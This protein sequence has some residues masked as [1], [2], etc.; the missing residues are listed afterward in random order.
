M[1]AQMRRNA[2]LL[3][4]LGTA[5]CQPQTAPGSLHGDYVPAIYPS[6]R[7]MRQAVT[8][9][10]GPNGAHILFLNFDGAA[11]TSGYDDSTNNV[12]QIAMS[13]VQYPA[14]DASPYTGSYTKATAEQAIVGYVQQYW[15]YVNAQVTTTR[16]TG[17]RYTMCMIGGDPSIV[18]GAQG[19]GA[20]GVA[21]LDCNNQVEENIVYAFADV[22][23][24]QNTGSVT[25][26]L[27][28][29]A[30]TCSQEMAHAFGLGHT[31][32]TADVQYPELSPSTVMG[33]ASGMHNIFDGPGAPQQSGVCG[34]GTTQDS[35][36][37]LLGV[38]GATSGMTGATPT[39][40]FIAPTNGQ[41][42]PLN[43]TIAVSA[44]ETGG[45]IAH[46]DVTSGGTNIATLT[47]PP[48]Q[49]Q[50]TAPSD[51]S[52]QL[53]ATAY[54]ANGN[55]ASATVT[56]TAKTGAPPQTL[57]CS[58]DTDCATGMKCVNG[59]CAMPGSSGNCSTPC[60]SGTTCQ[61]DGSCAPNGGGGG[62]G[63]VGG[64]GSAGGVGMSCTDGSEC[65]SGICAQ[66]GSKKFCTQTCD[67]GNKSSCPSNA[68]CVASGGDHVCEPNSLTGNG[69]G[70]ST[71][72]GAPEPPGAAILAAW[73]LAISLLLSSRR[74]RSA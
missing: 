29:I 16:P 19:Q 64:G 71:A 69:G 23:T 34:N 47:T 12:S 20:A 33:F 13:S 18:L 5:G 17:K 40:S 8:S 15:G 49:K 44:S 21:P 61:P 32:D 37:M 57:G 28:A 42:V 65:A 22:V 67:P 24:P 52:Y 41:T 35:H 48:Y 43:F 38:V 50:V 36:A 10:D 9:G 30:V 63:G 73:L 56:F 45:S 11:L 60:P 26:S 53:T 39:V 25:E 4:L 62:G 74:R 2:T 14:W 70:C 66:L 1:E 58:I 54:D 59:M 51:G 55:S 6:D 7:P 27:K 46:V 72:P 31:D 3:V 68:S